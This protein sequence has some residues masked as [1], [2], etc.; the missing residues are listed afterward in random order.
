MALVVEEVAGD[1]CDG[2]VVGEVELHLLSAD[3]FEVAA[4]HDARGQGRSRAVGDVVEQ[5]VLAGQ[6][7]GQKGLASFSNCSRVWTSAKTSMRNSEASS[8]I[9]NSLS[10]LAQSVR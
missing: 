8:M 7:Q 2:Q 10:F 1:P 3:A 6:H 9:S 4:G 5:V